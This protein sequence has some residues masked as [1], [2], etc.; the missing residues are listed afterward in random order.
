MESLDYKNDENLTITSDMELF[1]ICFW[2][3]NDWLMDI[4]R[5]RKFIKETEKLVRHSV[6]YSN[7]ISVVSENMDHCQFLGHI[8]KYDA[9]IECHHNFFS[10]YD[11]VSVIT[12]ALL[13]RK[14]FVNT[15]KVA[16]LVIDEHYAEHVNLVMLCKTAHEAVDTG[17][18]FINLSQGIGNLGEFLKKYKDGLT[19][20]YIDKLNEYIELSRKFKSTDNRI[21]ELEDAMVNWSYKSLPNDFSKRLINE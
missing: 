14:E 20:P 11:Y 21:F 8:S 18:I 5:Y 19:E 6:D 4:D 2:K 13:A 12:N 17:D 9:K 3:D 7:F 16:K 15:F 1:D 10:L